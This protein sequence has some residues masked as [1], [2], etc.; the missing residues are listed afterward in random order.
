MSR[1]AAV[2]TNPTGG[3]TNLITS[4][5]VF[6]TYQRTCN[7]NLLDNWYFVGGGTGSGV[8]P[9][10]RRGHLSFTT[11]GIDRWQAE[12]TGGPAV[13]V[14]TSGLYI[15]AGSNY[16]GILQLLEN[17]TMYNGKTLTAS[18]LALNNG[19]QE[20]KVI[21]GTITLPSTNTVL[22]NSGGD[23]S[24]FLYGS[25][26]QL[27]LRIRCLNGAKRTIVAVKIEIG[28]TQTL[29]HNEGTDANPVWVLNAIPNYTE[30]VER[31]LHNTADSNDVYANVPFIEATGYYYQQGY[32]INLHCNTWT[33]GSDITIP[34]P[35][36]PKR[37]MQFVAEQ[38][39]GSGTQSVV[40]RLT[41]NAAGTLTLAAGQ[42]HFIGTFTW[43]IGY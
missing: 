23:M 12:T 6:K 33:K 4:D 26:S 8:F 29:C 32:L 37:N 9:V 21:H 19:V 36:R 34:V 18:V 43:Q 2:D 27:S 40:S 35:Y 16:Q 28:D 39:A 20:F 42:T 41:V 15:D 13:S 30:Q 22:I 10:N 1:A 38:N 5:A 25:T 14:T 24:L 11:N 7:P 17:P 31:C 3:S